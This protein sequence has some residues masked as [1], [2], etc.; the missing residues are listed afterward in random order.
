MKSSIR[1]DKKK[2]PDLHSFYSIMSNS[3]GSL[4]SVQNMIQQF[5]TEFE[6]VF[7]SIVTH[8]PTSIS[9]LYIISC[10]YTRVELQSYKR[11][12]NLNVIVCWN[13]HSTIFNTKTDDDESVEQYNNIYFVIL[14]LKLVVPWCKFCVDIQNFKKLRIIVYITHHS[15]HD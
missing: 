11:S 9:L 13:I 7:R 12:T 3:Q 14:L 5:Q 4:K 8:H 1:V 15:Y 10:M 6:Q 2:D